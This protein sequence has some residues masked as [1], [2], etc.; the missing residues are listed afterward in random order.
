ML[1]DWV[2]KE[3]EIEG[4]SKGTRKNRITNTKCQESELERQLLELFKEFRSKGRKINKAWFI[5]HAKRIYEFIYPHR[6][7][8]TPGQLTQYSGFKFSI[9]WFLNF[10]KRSRIT[11][12][13]GTKT[14]T[15]GAR[16]FS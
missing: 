8:K 5:R 15:T 4:C 2:R 9:G 3:T 6:V 13:R 12:R 7:I 14:L 16:G 11:T 1:R 10:K